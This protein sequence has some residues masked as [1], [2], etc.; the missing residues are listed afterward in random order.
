MISNIKFIALSEKERMEYIMTTKLMC[1]KNG[2]SIISHTTAKAAAN[3][4]RKHKQINNG[5]NYERN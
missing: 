5:R 4:L 3:W 2:S 1:P